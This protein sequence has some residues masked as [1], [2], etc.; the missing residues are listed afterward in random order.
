[1]SIRIGIG[2]REGP[3]YI[4]YF[5]C[6][7]PTRSVAVTFTS[8]NH[9]GSVD[10]E[11]SGY[12]ASVLLNAGFSVVAFKATRNTWY[13]DIAEE[14]LQA[15]EL[16][17]RGRGYADRVAYGSSMGGFAAIRFARQLGVDRV[18]ALSPQFE[19]DKPW[20]IR[21]AMEA[22]E[23]TFRY[24]AEDLAGTAPA[25]ADQRRC[26]YFLAYDPY[27][28]LDAGHARRFAEILP[29]TDTRLVRIPF[30]GH[31]V[32]PFLSEIKA[33]KGFAL[34]ILKD[35][36]VPRIIAGREAKRASPSYLFQLALHGRARK[37]PR[38]GLAVVDAALRLNPTLPDL[39]LLKSI[40]LDQVDDLP[41]AV[42]E[43]KRAVECAP[44]T[45]HLLHQLAYLEHKSGRRPEALAAIDEAIG[46][47]PAIA[48]Y[49]N[50]R[51]VV[52]CESTRY[53]EAVAAIRRAIVIAPQE[54]RF[55][56]WL[57]TMRPDAPDAEAASGG[58]APA[59]SGA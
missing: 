48:E 13:Q 2:R 14:D 39:H 45:H 10:P 38:L 55:R 37:K 43:A 34:D 52:L 8:W 33:I 28:A 11:G 31:P 21:W 29:P 35:G 1:M 59:E 23:L 17:M 30:A 6:P 18:L 51:S 3:T 20:D 54:T 24:R 19:I 4:D 16:L 40:L 56:D 36:R 57:R 25:A 41:G 44:N 9:A 32:G 49:H 46:L 53:D 5:Q 26:T 42:A 58:V 50:F 15:V 7:A 47:Q 27:D 22:R 12:A